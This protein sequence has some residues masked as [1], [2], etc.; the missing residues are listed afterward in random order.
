[1]S[2]TTAGTRCFAPDRLRAR[3]GGRRVDGV[4]STSAASAPEAEAAA[5]VDLGKALGTD[6]FLLRED[7][8]ASEV[9]YLTRTRAFVE[10]EV[11]A[12]G[13]ASSAWSA[14]AWRVTAAP[15]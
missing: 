3:V 11:L 8:T 10:D 12:G 7:L 14:M 13:S 4:T 15:R 1:M 6:Y 2:P 9:E 5:S